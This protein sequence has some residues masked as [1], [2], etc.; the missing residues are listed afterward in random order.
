MKEK[1]VKYLAIRNSNNGELC[2]FENEAKEFEL[3]NIKLQ[4]Y[5]AI[6]FYSY[7]NYMKELY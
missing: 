5:Y 2:R 1:R 4:Y 3:Y 7:Y 6:F